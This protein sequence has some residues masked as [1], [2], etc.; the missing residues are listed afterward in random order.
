MNPTTAPEVQTLAQLVRTEL[1][2]DNEPRGFEVIY[3]GYIVF[4]NYEAEYRDAVGGSYENYEF[5]HIAELVSET[6][7][8]ADVWDAEGNEYP[9]MVN[10]LQLM[11]N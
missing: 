5:E 11:L 8:V 1:K 4:I 2:S 3:N 10:T 7:T 9:E 6:V